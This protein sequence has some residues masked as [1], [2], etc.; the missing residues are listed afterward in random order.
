MFLVA[1]GLREMDSGNPTRIPVVKQ[2]AVPAARKL[3]HARTNIRAMQ[4]GNAECSSW[5]TRELAAARSW[6]D[7]SQSAVSAGRPAAAAEIA[8]PAQSAAA[9]FQP[10]IP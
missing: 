3:F 6:R 10:L 7:A 9:P 2:H 8:A 5:R 1:I 4:H